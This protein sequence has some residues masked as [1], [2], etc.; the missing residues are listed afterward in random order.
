MNLFDEGLLVVGL[1]IMSVLIPGLVPQAVVWPSEHD[2]FLPLFVMVFWILCP[3]CKAV[4]QILHRVDRVA[5]L[6]AVSAVFAAEPPP[7]DLR[8][9]PIRV[10]A[11]VVG[12]LL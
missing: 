10:C 7:P 9:T 3:G 2:T 5:F 11:G 8:L 12:F 6:A 4:V 1:Y